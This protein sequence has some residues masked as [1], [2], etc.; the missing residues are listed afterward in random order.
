[1]RMK[2]TRLLLLALAAVALV[3]GG[4]MAYKEKKTSETLEIVLIPKAVDTSNE[5]WST[6]IAGAK[7]A[8][9]EYGEKL[10]IM[11][12]KAES[13]IE[14]QNRLIEEAVALEPDAVII[15]ASSFTE[16]APYAQKVKEHGIMLAFVDSEVEVDIADTVVATDNYQVGNKLGEYMKGFVKD[17]THIAIVGH[18]ANTS[19]A[20]DREEG[21][22]NGLGSSQDRIELVQYCNS[23][24]QDAYDLT[25]AIM[26]EHPEINMLAGSNEYSSVGA[27]K[28]V[29]D[30]GK[31]EEISVFGIDNSISEIQLLE[32]QVIRGLVIQN[33]FNMGYLSVK[34]VVM[35]KRE[36]R[37]SK[38]VDSGSTLI[39]KDTMYTEENQK[40]VF[41]FLGRQA[42]EDEKILE[43][44]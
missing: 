5:F 18:V 26:R 30:M 38:R 7:V 14:G 33:P 34:Q 35:A 4:R 42:T 40:L 17:D 3:A 9:N 31:Q 19:T 25:L 6:L 28:A 10:T 11:A 41:P 16:T 22:R 37:I 24:Y 21:I 13:D 15:A 39:T 32:E 2:K 12:P 1:M 29:K 23:I 20:I 27:A 43:M 36:S 44:Q 8:A